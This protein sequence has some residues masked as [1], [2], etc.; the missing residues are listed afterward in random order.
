ME[1]K[2][3]EI[4]DGDLEPGPVWLSPEARSVF[5]DFYNEHAKEAA[6]LSGDLAA[7]WSKL[8]EAAARL[9]LVHYLTRYGAG[10]MSTSSTLDSENMKAGI[11]MARWFGYEAKRVLAMLDETDDEGSQRRLVDWIAKRGGSVTVRET[12]QGHRKLRTSEDAEIALS[13]LVA[14][15][16]GRW[17]PKP[18]T[19]KGGQP[20]RVFELFT[21]STSTQP[22][23]TP[24]IS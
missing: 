1:L 16:Y 12:Q 10:D 5:V 18:P 24:G 9:A 20:T 21:A 7:V 22:P 15:G 4:T 19:S 2:P 14:A 8:E 6:E 13:E 23:K 11:T 3:V 17:D